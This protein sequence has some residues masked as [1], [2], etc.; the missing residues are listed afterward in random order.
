M[1]TPTT[2]RK[3]PITCERIVV[4]ACMSVLPCPFQTLLAVLVA[5]AIT[6]NAMGTHELADL[7]QQARRAAEGYLDAVRKCG[8]VFAKIGV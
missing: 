5:D 6:R 8:K 1:M 7:F 2:M 3:T 4:V